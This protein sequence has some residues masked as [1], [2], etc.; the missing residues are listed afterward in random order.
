M[1]KRLG[2]DFVTVSLGVL[3]G[4]LVVLIALLALCLVKVFVMPYNSDRLTELTP[5][6]SSTQ[7]AMKLPPG[8]EAMTHDDDMS[9]VD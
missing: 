3:D 5:A 4:L 7:A 9:L 8:I 6:T 2:L 1:N